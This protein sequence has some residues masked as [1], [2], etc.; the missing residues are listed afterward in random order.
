MCVDQ[1]LWTL[2]GQDDRRPPKEPS[3]YLLICQVNELA[4][5]KNVGMG[6]ARAERRAPSKWKSY[7]G[8]GNRGTG[9]PFTWSQ[10]NTLYVM[11]IA[12]APIRETGQKAYLGGNSL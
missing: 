9:T 7:H 3:K 8:L 4:L 12:C 2:T 11:R 6:V 10:S 1:V 5:Q